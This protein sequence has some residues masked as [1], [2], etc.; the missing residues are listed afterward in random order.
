MLT[1]RLDRVKNRQ[2]VPL[3]KPSCMGFL[4]VQKKNSKRLFKR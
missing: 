3:G 1:R 2:A 4:F